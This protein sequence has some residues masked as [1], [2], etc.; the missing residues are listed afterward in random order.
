MMTVDKYWES[1]SNK[2]AINIERHNNIC[3]DNRSNY[4]ISDGR[5]EKMSSWL[6]NQ[7]E[8]AMVVEWRHEY[9]GEI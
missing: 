2:T 7:T 3:S 8:K 4:E 6:N 9:L 5:N 1:I